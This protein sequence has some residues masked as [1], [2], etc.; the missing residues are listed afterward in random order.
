MQGRKIKIDLAVIK[1]VFFYVKKHTQFY[2]SFLQCYKEHRSSETIQ[3]EFAVP[4]YKKIAYWLRY[5]G[6]QN[7]HM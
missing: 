5:G 3:R 6:R 2:K 7:G 1:I 4:D